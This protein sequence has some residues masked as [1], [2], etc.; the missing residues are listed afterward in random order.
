MRQLFII[1][2]IFLFPSMSLSMDSNEFEKNM[3]NIQEDKFVDVENFLKNSKKSLCKDPEYYV[4]LLNYCL[5]KGDMGVIISKDKPQ[6]GNYL[7][8]TD[9]TTNSPAGYISNHNE[10]DKKLVL[11]GISETIKALPNF[12]SRLDIRFGIVIAALNIDRY[13]LVGNQFVEMLK[14]SR[15]IDNKWSWG[16]INSLEGNPKEFMIENI[17]A[18]VAKLFKVDDR[19]ADIAVSRISNALIQYYPT[20][21]Y[22][23]ANLGV[24]NLARRNYKAANKYLTDAQKI[25]PDDEIVKQNIKLLKKK[26]IKR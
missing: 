20:V 17:Q 4:I 5:A 26:N 23:Y 2:C 15:E 16:T 24:L 8:F 1:I 21:I 13:D 18:R 3:S 7:V 22:G 10:Y 12:K 6:S 14:V 25:D 19:N 9:T 11:K